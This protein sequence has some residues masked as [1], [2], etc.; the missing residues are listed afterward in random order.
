MALTPVEIHHKEFRTARFGGYNEEEVDSFLDLIADDFGKLIQD[1]SEARQQMEG[2]RQRLSEF[3]EMQ[4]S[5]QSALL[6]ASKSAE[7]M[8]EQ[9]RRESE[10]MV[11]KAQ[12]KTDAL[13]KSAQEEA[14]ALVK[15]ARDEAREMVLRARAERQELERNFARLKEVRERYL[16]S[17]KEGAKAHLLDMEALEQRE[18]SEFASEDASF[19]GAEEDLVAAEA[20]PHLLETRQAPLEKQAPPTQPVVQPSPASEPAQAPPPASEPE[21]SKAPEKP[22]PAV[23]LAKP[24]DAQ[25]APQARP[26]PEPMRPAEP[27][28]TSGSEAQVPSSK[29]V[30]EV[31]AMDGDEDVYGDLP[32]EEASSDKERRGSKEKKAKHFFWE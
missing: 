25:A 6:A 2:M 32:I 23:E 1:N 14:D 10:A 21:L 12:E 15:G 22:S 20:P 30:D 5:L 11:T 13:V 17:I 18:Q 26:K 28:V 24:P 31:L 9:A 29:L 3:E 27:K 4:T 19:L 16:Q 7:I 8:K